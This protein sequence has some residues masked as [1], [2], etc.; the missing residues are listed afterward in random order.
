MNNFFVNS[1][2]EMLKV[3]NLIAK[4]DMI[5]QKLLISETLSCLVYIL[6]SSRRRVKIHFSNH[7]TTMNNTHT[8]MSWKNVPNSFPA[9]Q[10]PRKDNGSVQESDNKQTEQLT[11]FHESENFDRDCLSILETLAFKLYGSQELVKNTDR[12]ISASL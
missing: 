2:I 6:N 12:V 8:T 3:Q 4:Y 11:K 1:H 10:L 9:Q 5:N 7:Y